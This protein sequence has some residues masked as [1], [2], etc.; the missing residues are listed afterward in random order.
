MRFKK[1]ILFNLIS[2]VIYLGIYLTTGKN[3]PADIFRTAMEQ[4][5]TLKGPPPDL[6]YED[7]LLCLSL[8]QYIDDSQQQ[9]AR[10]N[11]DVKKEEQDL[12]ILKGVMDEM[13]PERYNARVDSYNERLASLKEHSQRYSEKVDTHNALIAEEKDTCLN[14]SYL[15]SDYEAATAHILTQN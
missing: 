11:A 1:F 4:Q 2:P 5:E 7:I 6:T 3:I 9:L 12:L 14:K 15:N 8:K 10:D 13:P